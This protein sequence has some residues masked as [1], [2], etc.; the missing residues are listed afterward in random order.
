MY[1]NALSHVRVNG[2]FSDY[3]LV[4]VG[5]HQDLVLSLLS[6]AIVL[7]A[8][9]REIRSGCLEKLLYADNVTLFSKTLEG[10]KGK[11]ET[12]KRV[13]ESKWLRVN[14]KKTK[15]MIRSK[16]AVKVTIDGKFPCAVY[17]KGLGSNFIL[18]QFCRC[19]LHKR[20]SGFK[21]KLRDDSKFEYQVSANQ[22]TYIPDDCPDIVENFAILVTR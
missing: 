2:I 12:W 8:L 7:E 16:N 17:R 20:C 14:V 4:Q 13:L 15:M 6:I 1:W 19:W 10:L 18:C 22:Q 11:L 5:S 3:F 9:S 21:G